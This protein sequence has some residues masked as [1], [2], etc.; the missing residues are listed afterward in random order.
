MEGFDRRKFLKGT[1]V[2]AGLA[3]AATVVP[4]A[5]PALAGTPG[6]SSSRTRASKGPA[7]VTASSSGPSQPVV[8][9]VRDVSKGEIDVFVG[10]QHFTLRDRSLADRIVDAAR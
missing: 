8:A 4:G 1:S 9:H 7:P 10:T 5:L 2:A 6:S 3:G